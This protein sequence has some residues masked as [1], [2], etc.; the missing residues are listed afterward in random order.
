MVGEPGSR[1][2]PIAAQGKPV[3]EMFMGRHWWLVLVLFSWDP[4]RDVSIG[5]SFVCNASWDPGGG[6]LPDL[7]GHFVKVLLRGPVAPRIGNGLGVLGPSIA[8]RA[9]EAFCLQ[10]FL[11]PTVAL[12]AM[13]G[14]PG[15]RSGWIVSE[16]G[17]FKPFSSWTYA[18]R[19][20]SPLPGPSTRG[21]SL[22][23][24]PLRDDPVE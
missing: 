19:G 3:W 11:G 5:K 4:G 6:V 1:S 10:R 8:E 9:S 12:R 2:V 23:C 18:A 13:V 20:Y 22:G 17:T 16:G 24:P 21:H 15:S 14:K 7:S